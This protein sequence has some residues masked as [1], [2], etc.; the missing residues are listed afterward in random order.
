MTDGKRTETDALVE[1]VENQR[2][3][4]VLDLD[5]PDRTSHE[6]VALPGAN[7]T[8][9]LVSVKKTMDEYR[10]AP[11]RRKG[12]AVLTSVESFVAHVNRFKDGDSAIFVDRD[13]AHPSLTAVLDYHRRG[14]DGSPQFGEH[15]SK[16][17]F[18]ISDAWKSWHDK[19]GEEFSQAELAQF[20]EDN[21]ADVA[22]PDIAR[23]SDRAQT[24]MSVFKST[25][26]GPEKLLALSRALTVHV[27]EK[28]EQAVNPASGEVTLRFESTHT[29]NQT[30]IPTAFIL[31]IPVF[32]D[33]DVYILVARF[34]YRVRGGAVT[35]WY[36]LHKP[37][38]IFDDALRAVVK[39]VIDSTSLPVLAGAPEN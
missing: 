10:T 25:F 21:L 20:I 37:D 30:Q 36:N 9:S 8:W 19:N 28:V 2:K 35:L 16:Y 6:V 1:I 4:I 3:P 27:G 26:A 38:E 29:A 34:R 32:R 23:E 31:T 18:P 22:V 13:P 24:F 14:A 11:E 33:G 7:G 15:R 12:T 39:K 17:A 5:A